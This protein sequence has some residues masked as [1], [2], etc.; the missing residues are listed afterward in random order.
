MLGLG[1]HRRGDKT[2]ADAGGI[3]VRVP[4]RLLQ[5]YALRGLPL[6]LPVKQVG[7]LSELISS[8]WR[9]PGFEEKAVRPYFRPHTDESS[10]TFS[11]SVSVEIDGRFRGRP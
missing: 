6:V 2:M 1:L 5:K 4:P 3:V 10:Q 7:S 9:E 8:R 11:S